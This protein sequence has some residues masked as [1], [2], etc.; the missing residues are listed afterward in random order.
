MFSDEYFTDNAIAIWKAECISRC[1]DKTK[2]PPYERYINWK[3]LNNEIAVFTLYAYADFPI[4]KT[5]DIIFQTDNPDNFIKIDYELVQSIHEAWF[6]LDTV[7]HGHKHLCI[8]RFADTVPDIL[9]L[10]H[11][12]NEKFSTAPK[13]QK[14]LGFCNSKDFESIRKRIEKTLKLKEQYGDKWWEHDDD[15]GE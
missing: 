5:F 12:G 8:F 10:L 15:G 13:G 7:D 2:G 14:K 3:R 6:P 11:K 1:K 4:P 9:N